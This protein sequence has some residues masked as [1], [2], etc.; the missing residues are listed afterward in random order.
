MSVSRLFIGEF[1]VP[2]KPSIFCSLTL[3]GAF[4]HM[5]ACICR[6][7]LLTRDSVALCGTAGRCPHLDRSSMPSATVA[8]CSQQARETCL[9]SIAAM[10]IHFAYT[11]EL[12][13]F[14]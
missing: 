11:F 1:R 10:G 14:T 13:P 8:M 9:R 5:T 6:P 12:M 4:K 2:H 3:Y 7:L